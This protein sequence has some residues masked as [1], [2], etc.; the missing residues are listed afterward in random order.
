MK[1]LITFSLLAVLSVGAF[2]DE[3]TLPQGMI[4]ILP[5]G[6]QITSS[7]LDQNV[8]SITK[9]EKPFVVAEN[10]L[11][12]F[13]A[14]NAESGDELWVSDGTVSG[15]RIVKDIV[16]GSEGSDPKWLTVVGNLVYSDPNKRK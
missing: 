10:N 15:T 12:F 13:T 5:S 3:V 11:M 14:T 9:D 2:A 8:M 4:P 6:T 16:P 7:Y 1:H